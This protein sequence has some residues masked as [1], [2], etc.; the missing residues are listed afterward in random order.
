VAWLCLPC[1]PA[2]RPCQPA[3]RTRQRAASVAGPL[4]R[5]DPRAPRSRTGRPS[6]GC[7]VARPR[8]RRVPDPPRRL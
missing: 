8:R 4:G 7:R 1:R 5:V 6:P 2:G 3:G